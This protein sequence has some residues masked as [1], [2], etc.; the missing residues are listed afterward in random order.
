MAGMSA[1]LTIEDS[2]REVARPPD[3]DASALAAMS[4]RVTCAE[5]MAR[6]SS[7]QNRQARSNIMNGHRSLAHV[8]A[9]DPLAGL[10]EALR[11]TRPDA[12]VDLL[13]RAYDVAARCHQGQLRRSG[14]PYVTHPVSVATI[15]TGLGA[16]DQTLCAAILHDTVEDTPYTLTA[17]SREFGPGTAAMVAGIMALDGSRRRRGNKLARAIAAAQAADT[18]VVE[19]K[20]ADR[21]HNMQ[22]IRFLPH[23]KQLHRARQSLDIF[24]PVAEQLSMP[25]VTS[26]LET[27]AA[28][29]LTRGQLDGH[30]LL[31]R[32][33]AHQR[34]IVALDIERSTSRPDDVKAELRQTMYA[35]FDAAL[36]AAGIQPRHR[37]R[38]AD[39]GD[40][41]LALIHP[42]GDISKVLLRRVIPA[43]S[44]LLAEHNVGRPLQRQLRVRVV[45]HAGTVFY[46]ANGCFGETLDA[47]FRLLDAPSVKGALQAASAPL[48]LVV[49]AGLDGFVRTGESGRAFPRVSVQVASN[50]YEGRVS[51]LPG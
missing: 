32:P 29:T 12:D 40:G 31:R 3:P 50:E 45:V 23:A 34:T 35:L 37:E 30:G 28:A 38:F 44:L 9:A 43:F 7:P 25:T 14:D 20:L 47:A 2:A 48:V 26:E 33:R 42:V 13:R 5:R 46:D 24:V 8:P 49:S 21:L 39:R 6:A 16:D 17:M 11:T 15:L 1:F 41:F 19:M 22:T 51:L 4:I 10:W 18:R 27:L 36:R